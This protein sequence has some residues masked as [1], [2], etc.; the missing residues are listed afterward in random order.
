MMDLFRTNGYQFGAF[1]SAPVYGA[2]ALDR[3]ALSR[4]PNLRLQTF[5]PYPGAGHS[6][7]DRHMTEE[8]HE[9]LARRGPAMS[10]V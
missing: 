8:W 5:A 4:V 9:W 1:T 6:G 10:R 7:K 3:T 2:V